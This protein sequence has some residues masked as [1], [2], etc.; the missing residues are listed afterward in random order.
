MVSELS[1][2]SSLPTLAV[3]V[4]DEDSQRFCFSE[5]YINQRA[6]C[7]QCLQRRVAAVSPELAAAVVR[8]T[9]RCR[10]ADPTP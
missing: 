10:A 9:R 6:H 3:F 1:T 4:D 8:R 2:K 7:P 5:A